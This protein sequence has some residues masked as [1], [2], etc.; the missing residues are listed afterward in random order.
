MSGTTPQRPYWN[1]PPAELE[2]VW[3]LAKRGKVARLVLLT[4]PLGW[5]LRIESGDLLM[6]QVC[7]SDE[8]IQEVSAGWKDAMIEKGWSA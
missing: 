2:T 7:R 4:H 8:E 5:E 3:A 1:G 6:T